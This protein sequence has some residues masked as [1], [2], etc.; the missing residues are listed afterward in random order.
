MTLAGRARAAR[1]RPR[2]WPRPD[3]R[4]AFEMR[5]AALLVTATLGC[6]SSRA[7][8]LVLSGE[9]HALR[10]HAV[11][12]RA[13]SPE[14]PPVMLFALDGVSRPQLYAIIRAGEL[15]NLAALLGGDRLA[16]AYLSSRWC[17]AHR[18]WLDGSARSPASHPRSTA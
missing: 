16:H 17:A 10:P 8:E 12:A 15:P 2:L 7:V 11:R 13:S 3:N 4:L 6:A 5:L 9:V 18:R 1:E 14:A